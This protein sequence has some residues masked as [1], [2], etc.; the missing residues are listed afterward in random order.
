MNANRIFTVLVER[1]GYNKQQA[2][3]LSKDL[4]GIAEEIRPLFEAWINSGDKPDHEY[5]GITLFNLISST[6]MSY[7]A[8][9]STLDWLLKDSDVALPVINKMMRTE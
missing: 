8:A 3:L 5:K 6:G 7:P 9:V 1:E 4:A 2:A